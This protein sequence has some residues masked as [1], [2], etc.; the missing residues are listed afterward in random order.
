MMIAKWIDSPSPV[1]VAIKSR[2]VDDSDE[3]VSS[4]KFAGVFDGDKMA[5]AFLVV[6]W[7]NFCFQIHGGVHP[8]FWG[9]GP[10]ICFQAGKLI[11]EQTSCL[12]IVAIIPEF[13][14]LMRK[15]VLKCGMVQEGIIKKSY[16]KWFRLHDQYVYGITK[17]EYKCLRQP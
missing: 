9:H 14:S 8:D 15:C 7:S 10:R 17:G 3:L 11:F 6:P 13:N 12:K 1:W 4:G 5:G 16:L 2:M